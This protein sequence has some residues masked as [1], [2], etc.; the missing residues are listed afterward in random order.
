MTKWWHKDRKRVWIKKAIEILL[1]QSQRNPI[2]VFKNTER[3]TQRKKINRDTD[4]AK[5]A[6][7]RQRYRKGRKR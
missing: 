3:D 7:N 1:A 5:T 6:Q 2:M 4:Y